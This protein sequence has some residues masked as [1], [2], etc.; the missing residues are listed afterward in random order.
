MNNN[1]N[2]IITIIINYIDNNII[3]III[4]TDVIR[5][6]LI[7]H[8]SLYFSPTI[9]LSHE[10]PLPQVA[11]NGF[12]VPPHSKKRFS[13][14]Y[15]PTLVSTHKSTWRHNPED[16]IDIFITM[17]TSFFIYRILCSFLQEEEFFSVV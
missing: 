14:S 8:I 12:C 7:H 3:I 6:I 1:N 5:E 2:N 17:I 11:Y 10:P 9:N 16:I 4:S 15:K 13:Q